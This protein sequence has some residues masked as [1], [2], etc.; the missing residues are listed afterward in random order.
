MVNK[1]VMFLDYKA[2]EEIKS[3][4]KRDFQE[5]SGNKL[6]LE[7]DGYFRQAI[8]NFTLAGTNLSEAEDELNRILEKFKQCNQ[9][10]RQLPGLEP[11]IAMTSGFV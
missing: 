8:T 1:S 10:I 5:G 2:H 4:S 6:M 3:Q 11:V 9:L 7:A